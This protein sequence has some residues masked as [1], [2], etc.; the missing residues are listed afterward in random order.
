MEVK[1]QLRFH[2]LSWVSEVGLYSFRGWG[3]L[4]FPQWLSPCQVMILW[5]STTH[6]G[7]FSFT[8]TPMGVLLFFKK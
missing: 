8:Q 1:I 7:P 2:E 6:R 4:F 5:G 3:G